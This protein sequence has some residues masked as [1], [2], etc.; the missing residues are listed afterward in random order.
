M[1]I[2]VLATASSG[3]SSSIL[4]SYGDTIVVVVIFIMLMFRRLRRGINGSVYSDARVIRSPI[5]MSLLFAFF[6]IDLVGYPSYLGITL[7][8][9]IPGLMFGD[10][11]G[12]LTKVYKQNNIIM[13]KRNLIL[14]GVTSTLVIIRLVMEF[15]VNLA[16]VELLTVLNCLIALSLGIY[17][18]EA[19]HIRKKARELSKVDTD[20]N[21]VI[22]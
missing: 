1:N 7:I 10:R 22:S 19:F 15:E 14:L 16:N 20:Q 9:I 3:G 5:V 13:Y 12:S 8:I 6:S 2:F 18:G 17:A 21:S 11:F 4:Q